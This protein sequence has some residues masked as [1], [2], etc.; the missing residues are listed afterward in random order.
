MSKHTETPTPAP[1]TL[2]EPTQQ[3]KLSAAT[4]SP[5]FASDEERFTFGGREFVVLDLSYDNYLDFI[6]LLQPLVDSIV[7]GV[8]GSLFKKP[9]SDLPGIPL[10]DNFNFS[11]S[12]IIKY[13]GKDLPKLAA[14]VM[15]TEAASKE[16]KASL[17]T[18]A[19]VRKHAKSPMELVG[20]VMLQVNKNK[21][22]SEIGSFFVQFLPQFQKAKSLFQT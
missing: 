3:Q 4:N 11:I 10:Q 17:V 12:S 5:A 16:E 18:D 6:A 1:E 7:S 19:W 2:P 20:I 13:C 8:A 21:M 22:I 15:N 9:S 14:I